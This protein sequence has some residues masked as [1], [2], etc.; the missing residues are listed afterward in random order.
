MSRDEKRPREYTEAAA[1]Q[2]AFERFRDRMQNL[3]RMPKEKANELRG[4]SRKP[5]P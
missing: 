2:A 1:G 3:V 5:A 4:P